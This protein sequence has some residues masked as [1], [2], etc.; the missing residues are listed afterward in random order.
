MRS[1]NALHNRSLHKGYKLPFKT[2]LNIF[3][4]CDFS[5]LNAAFLGLILTLSFSQRSGAAQ[6]LFLWENGPNLSSEELR[7]KG[8]HPEWLNQNWHHSQESIFTD[9]FAAA[10]ALPY[11][12]DISGA[13]LHPDDPSQVLLLIED[14]NPVSPLNAVAKGPILL[15]LNYSSR[16]QAQVWLKKFEDPSNTFV[17]YGT[18]KKSRLF[19]ARPFLIDGPKSVDLRKLGSV[20][21]NQ[22]S[23]TFFLREAQMLTFDMTA[24]LS[25]KPAPD[26]NERSSSNVAPT[27]RLKILILNSTNGVQFTPQWAEISGRENSRAAGA[28]DEDSIFNS[29]PMPAA[30][31]AIKPMHRLRQICADLLRIPF[32][33]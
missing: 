13:K 6:L 12:E 19:G 1:T 28:T 33:K 22:D 11:A 27:P 2:R 21:H 26:A 30:V 15:A 5:I 32:K 20:F 14:R 4:R 23:K 29:A 31:A 24:N 16:H 25:S 3:N 10:E 7:E 9:P 17:I 18:T 8:R